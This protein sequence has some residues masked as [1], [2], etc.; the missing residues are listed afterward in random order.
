[1]TGHASSRSY[2]AALTLRASPCSYS[3]ALALRAS[4]RSYGTALALR[5]SPCSYSAALPLR[6]SPCSYGAALISGIFCLLS[7]RVQ[8]IANLSRR[9]QNALS[10]LC[11]PGNRIL[12]RCQ[13]HRICKTHKRTADRHN[14]GQ[15]SGKYL[16]V[17][18]LICHCPS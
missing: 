13:I 14:G 5:V 12:S 3:A 8:P 17:H 1:M 9:R 7:R 2:S 16:F 11:R 6:A 4:S 15:H 18:I 10:L